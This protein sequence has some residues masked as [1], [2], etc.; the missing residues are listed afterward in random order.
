[1]PRGETI[2]AFDLSEPQSGSDVAGLQCA[3]RIEGEY[4][5]LDGEK[6]WISNGG[7]ADLYVVINRTVEAPGARG[8]SAFIVDAGTPGVEIAERME[9]IAPHTLAR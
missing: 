9:V 6:T 3:A 2:A 1:M 5:V 8:I 7:I 4:A